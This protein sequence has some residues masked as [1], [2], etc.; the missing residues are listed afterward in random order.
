MNF[1]KKASQKP[2]V[3]I[4]LAM[5]VIILIVTTLIRM[6]TLDTEIILVQTVEMPTLP[7]LTEIKT[8]DFRQKAIALDGRIIQGT[9]LD[10][11]PTAST[12]KMILSLVVM[13]KYP[14]TLGSAGETIEITPEFYDKYL[15]YI[16]HNGSNT[17]VAVGEAISQYDAI[18]SI[19]LASSNNMADSLA[20][21]AFGSLE[22]Y[23][24]F[25]A[26]FL[27]SI[28]TKN[29]T[30]GVDA[31]GYSETTTSTAE[32][33]AIIANKLLENPVL[34]EIVRLKSHTVP[35]AGLIKN[36]NT[37]LGENLNNGASVIGVKTGYIGSISGYNL[38]SAYQMED[39]YITLSLLGAN[40]RAAS[41]EGSREE[42]LRLSSELIPTTIVEKDQKVGY[43]QTWWSGQHD[44]LA[45]ESLRIFGFSDGQNQDGIT[46]ENTT[47]G[48]ILT[49]R[50]NGVD[51]TTP[52][53]YEDFPSEP[54]FWQRF[55]RLFGWEAE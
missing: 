26:D 20:I 14:F 22:N 4:G 19:L 16:S 8:G 55:L 42:L 24:K 54:T 17:P 36:T 29:T 39:H 7:V 43:Y 9:N 53:T 28:G 5:L 27:T 12:A 49:S 3:F 33:L 37:I 47:D 38:I 13:E 44:I 32:D 1:T 41:F 50:I 40:T 51:Y 18:A 46:A 2:R 31:C 15:W 34:R 35:V 45:T 30:I 21:W 23:Q 52:T 10:P 25:A 11:Q 6:F 48:V